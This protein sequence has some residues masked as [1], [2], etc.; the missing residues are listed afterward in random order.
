MRFILAGEDGGIP[1]VLSRPE[2]TERGTEL[3]DLASILRPVPRPLRGDRPVVMRLRLAK[4]FA[5]RS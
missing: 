5:N 1:L 3:F 4:Q 2:G